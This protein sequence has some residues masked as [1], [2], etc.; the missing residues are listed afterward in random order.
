MQAA[1]GGMRRAAQSWP[2]TLTGERVPATEVGRTASAAQTDAAAAQINLDD[3]Q[4]TTVGQDPADKPA[5]FARTEAKAEVA[6]ALKRLKQERERSERAAQA[7]LAKVIS[8][9]SLLMHALP[10]PEPFR[11]SSFGQLFALRHLAGGF[12]RAPARSL[13]I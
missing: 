3:V 8:R 12:A 10:A 4:A 11:R 5:T 9:V 7:A 1:A 13:S 6:A 2:A